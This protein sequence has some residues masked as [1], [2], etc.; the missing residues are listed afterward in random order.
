MKVIV[1]SENPVKINAIRA[2]FAEMFPD[3]LFDFG[4]VTVLSGVSDQPRDDEETLRGAM[5]RLAAVEAAAPDADYWAAIEGGVED[6]GGEME[7]FAWI[8]VKDTKGRVGKGRA[9]TFFVPPRVAALIRGGM[10]LGHANDA[11]FNKKNSKQG[12]GAVG[13]LTDDL[14]TRTTYYIHPAILALIPFKNPEL[15]P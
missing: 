7:V 15:Y 12:A 1:A 8:V 10:E 3:E 5:N 11:V 2:A 14:I 4:G 9:G 13:L 6:K